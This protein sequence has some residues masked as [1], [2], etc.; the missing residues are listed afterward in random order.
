[1]RGFS[2]KFIGI[3][4]PR[5]EFYDHKEIKK[6]QSEATG[7][8]KEYRTNRPLFTETQVLRPLRIPAKPKTQGNDRNH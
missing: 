5:C 8:A 7:N 1:M 2:K 6:P 3:P 4:E